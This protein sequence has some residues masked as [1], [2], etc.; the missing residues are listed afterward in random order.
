MSGV[1]ALATLAPMVNW[2]CQMLYDLLDYC[3]SINW[4]PPV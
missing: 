1:V 2:G 4:V 3:V